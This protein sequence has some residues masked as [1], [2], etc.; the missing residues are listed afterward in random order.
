MVFGITL[1]S[2]TG[3][4]IRTQATL[5]FAQYY[6]QNKNISSVLLTIP[7]ILAI[8]IAIVTP[9]LAKK[10]GKRN[11]VLVGCIVAIL[12]SVGIY[13]SKTNITAI[14]VMSVISAI[15]FALVSGITVVLSADVIDYGEW[16]TGVRAQGILYS[17]IGQE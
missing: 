11:L 7:T 2:F 1:L 8:P 13:I 10:F 16:K 12:G 5:Y 15:G 17:L 4:V 6:L 9:F 3:N 14:L